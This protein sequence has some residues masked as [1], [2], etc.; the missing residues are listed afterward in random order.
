MEGAWSFKEG[1]MKGTSD[2]YLPVIFPGEETLKGKIIQV[3][4]ERVLEDRM[5]GSRAE[6]KQPLALA[7]SLQAA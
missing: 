7:F 1:F 4:M 6:W 3:R 2:N 5:A